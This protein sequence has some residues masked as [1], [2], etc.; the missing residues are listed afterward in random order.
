MI[1]DRF[2]S[3]VHRHRV[4]IFGVW[5][6][7][8][9]LLHYFVLGF[10]SWDGFGHRGFPL[11]ELVQHGTMGK[12]K[13][14]EWSLVGYTPFVELANLPFLKLFGLKGFILGF[15]LVVFPL[16]V[17]AVHACLNELTGD[18]RTATFGAFA[19]AAIPMI[20]QQPY[21]G[22]IDFAVSGLLAFFLFALLRLRSDTRRRAFLRL[23]FATFLFT[24]ARVQ[25]LY[26]AIILFPIVC[27]VVFCERERFRIRVT[28]PRVLV[29]AAL[30]V[31]A[32]AV[33]A[34]ALQVWRY[35][36]FGSPT[37]PIQFKMLG[38]AVGDGGFTRDYY[39]RLAGLE[40]DGLASV[41]KGFWEGWVWHEGWP[42]GAFYA[43]RYLAAGGLFILAVL[44][45]PLI[46]RRL[47]RLELWILAGFAAVSLLAR[48]F[49]VPRWGY[50][51]VVAMVLVIGRAMSSLADSRRGRLAFWA[52]V[53]VLLVHLFRPEVDYLQL[54][55]GP[56]SPRMNVAGSSAYLEGAYEVS[57]YPDIDGRFVIV[58]LT[59]NNFV[60][61]VFGPKLSNQ[62]LGTVTGA[63]IGPRC[64]NLASWLQREPR[65]LFIDDHDF[66]KTCQRE[67][68]VQLRGYCRAWKITPP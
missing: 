56:V 33:P 31:G 51:I 39:F 24:M 7:H 48:D 30:A 25:A 63:S 43:S 59:G 21:S 47:T 40:G 54:K 17:W 57:V 27:Y 50:T 49:A 60:T 4:T 29:W 10:I 15:P 20:N 44:V 61:N 66:T 23:G 14:N 37:Y 19:Y 67:C 6:A 1:S 41:A 18:E 28:Q 58:E 5:W 3:F 9:F 26:V 32:G 64:E 36:E 11:V 52:M 46:A 2:S 22:Y 16:C 12:A 55:D 53:A 8:V 65:A 62:I 68:V 34:I 35:L 38:I 45:V 42:I 13:Y